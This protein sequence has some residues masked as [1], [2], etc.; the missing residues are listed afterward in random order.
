MKSI[1]PLILLCFFLNGLAAQNSLEWFDNYLVEWRSAIFDANELQVKGDTVLVYGVSN[2][3]DFAQFKMLKYDTLGN[4]LSDVNYQTEQGDTSESLIYDWALDEQEQPYLFKN[5]PISYNKDQ[6]VLQKFNSDGSLIWEKQIGS[7]SDTSFS[8]RTLGFL[9]DSLILVTVEKTF[10]YALTPNEPDPDFKKRHL[11]FGFH[12]NGDQLWEIELNPD[13]IKGFYSRREI[14]AYKNKWL[15]FGNNYANNNYE[16]I[17]VSVSIDGSYTLVNDFERNISF[18]D[19]MVTMDNHFLVKPVRDFG[20]SKITESGEVIWTYEHPSNI[21]DSISKDDDMNVMVED[22][23]GNVYISGHHYGEG[24]GTPA[25][26]SGDVLT[27]K[28]D[29]EGNFLWEDRYSFEIKNF[30]TATVIKYKDGFVY[31]GGRS[32]EPNDSPWY[33]FL[34]LKIDATSGERVGEYRYGGLNFA[35][36]MVVDLVVLESG[37]LAFTGVSEKLFGIHFWATQFISQLKLNNLN[38]QQQENIQ[39]YPNPISKNEPLIIDNKTANDY[40]IFSLLGQKIKSGNLLK[41][42]LNYIDLSTLKSGVY[43]LSF[44][45]GQDYATKKIIV[46]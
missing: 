29:Q 13:Q 11:L 10:N 7:S 19:V 1:F 23:E 46:P 6:A 40:Q 24:F 33:D 31:V 37:S 12:K 4:V 28:L 43:L 21:P 26:T 45:D 36:E 41:N 25:S 16:D 42:T 34:V 32:G 2:N 17:L 22:E 3:V 15:V 44:Q 9:N 5:I 8:A 38:I 20:I 39:V 18:T 14:V 27:V 35:D 30:E